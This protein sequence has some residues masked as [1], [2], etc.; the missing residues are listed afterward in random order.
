MTGYLAIWTGHLVCS[1]MAL[2][3]WISK[4]LKCPPGAILSVEISNFR[5]ATRYHNQAWFG[6]GSNT[7]FDIYST[8]FLYSL[9][10]RAQQADY[11]RLMYCI[12]FWR[13]WL[14]INDDDDDET[15]M[16][17]DDD[18]MM[19]MMRQWWDHNDKK[20]M[21]RWWWQWWVDDDDVMTMTRQW[22][23]WHDDN[24]MMMIMNRRGCQDDDDDM[25]MMTRQ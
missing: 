7:V 5:S 10:P 22:G 2:L 3:M 17:L 4:N 8:I 12:K 1:K 25:T 18:E 14:Q 9:Q 15:I 16:T 21:R 20:T 23:W 13:N 6:S 11:H 19:T 24:E